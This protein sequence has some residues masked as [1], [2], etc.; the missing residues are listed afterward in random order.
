[1]RETLPYQY[2]NPDQVQP[3]WTMATDYALADHLFQTQ[4]SGSFTAHQ[5][6]I[7]GGTEIDSTE[8]LI[9]D[10]TSSSAWGCT[11]PPGTKTSLITTSLKL[12]GAKGAVPVHER[13]PVVG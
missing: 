2:V 7:R 12:R 11:S 9:D 5:D 4:G 13:V 1:M 8:S 10:P 6:L 3:Y